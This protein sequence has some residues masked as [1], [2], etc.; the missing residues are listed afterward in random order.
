MSAII[1]FLKSVAGICRTQP[2]S[3]DC[4]QLNGNKATVR[5]GDV[6]ELQA[7]G[8]AVYLAGKGLKTPVLGIPAGVKI[9]SAVFAVT[10]K[11]CGQVART[12]LQGNLKNVREAEVMDIDENA[13][14]NGAVSAKLYGYLLVPEE[15][16]YI[17]SVKAGAIRSEGAVLQGIAAEVIDAMNTEDI[18]IIGPGTTTRALMER[19]GLA[20]TLLGVDIIRDRR[21]VAND[22]NENQLLE[23]ID[24]KPAKIVVTVI[25][26]QGHI[27]GR[28]N[29]QLSPRVMRQVGIKNIIVIAAKEKVISLSGKPL[30]VDTG[31]EE[32]NQQ[33]SGYIRIVTGYRD[34]VMYKVGC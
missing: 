28:G 3:P 21:L 13:F 1:D 18:Y 30:L 8:G 14:R 20:N 19:L 32:L 4:W 7:P 23:I 33:L 26:G 2:L 17:Q 11:I 9:H 27:F 6:A 16:R 12:F 10:P 25:G 29:Q 31:D 24:G 34:Y 5:V 15:R 22:V